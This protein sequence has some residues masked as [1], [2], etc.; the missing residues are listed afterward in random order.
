MRHS[1]CSAMRSSSSPTTPMRTAT[2]AM[3]LKDQG[4]FEEAVDAYRAIE[5]KPTLADAHN[6]LG[7]ALLEQGRLDEAIAAYDRAIQLVPDYAE[8]HNNRGSVFK[9]QGCL[10]E[11]LACFRKAIELKP[12]YTEAASNLLFT[13]HFHPEFDAQAILAE[14]R[15][16]ARQ[17]AEP[18]AAEQPPHPNDRESGRRLRSRIPVARLP[19]SPRRP[20]A[21]AAVL[22]SRSPASRVYRLLRRAGTRRSHRETQGAGRGVARYRG[23]E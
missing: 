13:L 11:A 23:P 12:D 16:W 4:R 17:Y 22:R 5:R 10:D 15:R 7:N 2:W 9:D 19:R 1:P 21:A 8:A 20:V 14:H 6:N 18:L 3:S